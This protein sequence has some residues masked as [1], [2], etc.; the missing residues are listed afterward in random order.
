MFERWL[1]ILDTT[2]DTGWRGPHTEQ[3][4]RRGYGLAWA[5]AH[6]LAGV[7][8]YVDGP[9]ERVYLAENQRAGTESTLRGSDPIDTRSPPLA[10]NML[11][12]EYVNDNS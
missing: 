8:S 12:L 2:L 3:I 9:L 11:H 6:R 7:N 4:R 1:E 5:M 10:I